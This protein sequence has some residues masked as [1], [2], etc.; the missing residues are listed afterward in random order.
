MDG[1][2]LY[3]TECG[4][5]GA[6]P[7]FASIDGLNATLS[8]FKVGEAYKGYARP[9]IMQNGAKTYVLND[10]PVSH[11]FTNNGNKKMTNPGSLTL[12]KQA[13]TIRLGKTASLKGSVKGVRKGKLINH[14]AK[15][16]YIS[17]NPAVATVSAKGKVKAVG[18][19]SC[20]IYVLTLNGIWQRVPVTVDAGP[21]KVKLIKVKKTMAIGE[22]QALAA[23]LVLKPAGAVTTLTW[24][25]SNPAVA[26]VDANGVVTA[27]AKGKVTITVTT[28]NGK[29]AGVKIKGKW[30]TR[31]KNR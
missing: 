3:L 28:A 6:F 31:R 20:D 22:T 30:A 25:S 1:F 21:A 26:S 2:D 17:S 8:G 4:N 27:L 7:L 10:T 11:C 16:R 13:L 23:K 5:K 29:K 18:A 19:G 12:K 9:W 24:A 14:D 15:L